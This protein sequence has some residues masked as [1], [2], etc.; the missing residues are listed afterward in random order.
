MENPVDES[1]SEDPGTGPGKPQP[2][3]PLQPPGAAADAADDLQ[4]PTA[5]ATW[6]QGQVHCP[7][8]LRLLET[9]LIG[10]ST[11]L[12]PSVLQCPSCGR[13]LVSHR[14]EWADG[15]L[16]AKVRYV[17]ISLLY[18]PVCAGLALGSTWCACA[19]LQAPWVWPS[20]LAATFWAAAVGGLQVGRLARSRRRVGG[21]RRAAHRP[22]F[23]SL[24]LF[25]PQ[26]VLI[27]IVLSALAVGS[28]ATLAA[29]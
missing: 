2:R 26:K 3:H 20:I 1:L 7:F 24:D 9:T 29:K 23:W 19:I 18:L 15:D 4:L 22:S 14:C 27:G 12:G 25:L 11:R 16:D 28:L 10:L 13:L 17:V 6:F 21:L 5:T 8:C